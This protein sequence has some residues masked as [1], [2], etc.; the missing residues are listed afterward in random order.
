M[1]H[2]RNICLMLGICLVMGLPSQGQ[3]VKVAGKVYDQF[4][5]LPGASVAVEGST[6]STS[7][8]VNGN[9][10]MNIDP[11]TYKIVAGFV[12]YSDKVLQVDLE[13]G[14][15]IYLDFQLESGFSIDQEVNVGTRFT[16][17]ALQETTVPIDIINNAI[18]S[19]SPQIELGQIMHYSAASFHST[20]QTISDGTDFIDPATLRGL[21][22]DQVLVLIKIL[23]SYSYSDI[24]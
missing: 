6:I 2:S 16:P 17:R 21:G 9:F 22:P 18:L 24:R 5:N 1:I 3:S 23:K 7:T 8:D 20:H 4:G 15:S 10:L 14:D 12:M 13:A 11:G 19:A